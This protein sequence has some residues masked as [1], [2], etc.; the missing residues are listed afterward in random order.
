MLSG[1]LL[2]ACALAQPGPFPF[3]SAKWLRDPRHEGHII[4]NVFHRER[5]GSNEAP[6]GPRNLHTLFRHE[7]TLKAPPASAVLVFSAD[8]YAVLYCNGQR[9]GQGPEGGYPWAHPFQTLEVSAFLQEGLNCLGA[10][11]FYQ[12]LVNRVWCS[13]DNRSGFALVL[14][15]TYEDGTTETVATDE[16]WRC[17]PLR[18]FSGGLQDAIS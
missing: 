7:F 3:E 16:S 10:H 2:M 1:L 17:L 18:A 5:E 9:M 14:R 13:G 8:D 15:V 4:E 11:V 6:P 12:G